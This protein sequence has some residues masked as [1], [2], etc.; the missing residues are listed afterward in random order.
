MRPISRD[1]AIDTMDGMNNN[2]TKT[3][4]IFYWRFNLLKK[5]SKEQCLSKCKSKY[6]QGRYLISLNNRFFSARR[7]S[8]YVGWD[9]SLVYSKRKGKR[10]QNE[11]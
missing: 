8:R 4:I 6:R 7:V 3:V 5:V 2:M 9:V 10:T 1:V 11:R